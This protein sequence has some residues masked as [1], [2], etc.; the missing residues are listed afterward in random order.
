MYAIAFLPLLP[1]V[2]IHPNTTTRVFLNKE[3]IQE[4][5]STRKKTFM[6]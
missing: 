2:L 3:S 5:A 1:R 4:M 6:Y